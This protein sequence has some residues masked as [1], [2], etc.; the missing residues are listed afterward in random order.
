MKYQTKPV[1]LARK[2]NIACNQMQHLNSKM[3]II[4]TK[5][6]R[7]FCSRNVE[8][9]LTQLNVYEDIYRLYYF[10]VENVAEKIEAG[11]YHVVQLLN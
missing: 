11:S 10:Y 5:L 1:F 3:K 8:S 9:L 7:Y 2:L 6:K 4:K